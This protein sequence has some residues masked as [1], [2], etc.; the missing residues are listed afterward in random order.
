MRPGLQFAFI[1]ATE[2]TT[3]TDAQL[4]ANWAG[5]N[6]A[7]LTRGVCLHCRCRK[8]LICS[9][10]VPDCLQAYHFGHPSIDPIAQ[11]N[12]FIAAVNAVGGYPAGS[13][14]LQFVLD[15]ED[16]DGLGSD[17]VWAWVQA[18]MAQVQAL[19]G[20]PGIIYTGWVGCARNSLG[21]RPCI[22][23]LSL[24]QLATTRIATT[25]GRSVEYIYALS[26]L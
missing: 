25:S 1:K 6:A 16:A 11:A 17:A 7:G 23:A 18:F 8:D 2:G 22:P 26:G 15:L 5:A 13:N 14:T 3:Y 12:Y 21:L 20:R 19:T 24:S 9:Y 10:L 4:A